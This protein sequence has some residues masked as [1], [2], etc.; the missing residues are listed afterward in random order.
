MTGT[1]TAPKPLPPYG[2]IVAAYQQESI[3]LEFPIY[4]YVGKSGKSEAYAQKR[5]GTMC[6]YLPYGDSADQYQWP[7]ENQKV[8]IMDTGCSVP[9]SLRR[10]AAHLLTYKPRVIFIYEDGMPGELIVP[11]GETYHG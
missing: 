8:V 9:M 10:M 4:I 7:I 2:R 6:M 5:I 1:S 11:K 3:K